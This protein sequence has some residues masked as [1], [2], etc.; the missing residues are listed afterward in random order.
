ML[1]QFFYFL[2]LLTFELLYFRVAQQLN[3]KDIPNERSSHKH[4]T[5]LG[6]GLIFVF[7]ILLFS[8]AYN[9]SYPWMLGG[10]IILAV[11]SFMDDIKPLSY[12]FRLAIQVAALLL[13]FYE[14]NLYSYPVIVVVLVI[15]LAT[16]VLNAYNF[17]DGINGL[18]GLSTLVVLGGMIYVNQFIINFVDMNFLY[19]MFMSVLIFNF[20]N[21]RKKAYCFAGDVG[22][23]TM[24]FVMVFLLAR[25]ISVSGDFTWITMLTIFGVDPLF[26]LIHRIFLRE[27]LTLPHRK[28]LFQ[29]FANELNVSHLV[30]ATVYATIQLFII[31]GLILCQ[32]YAYVFAI[33]SVVILSVVYILVKKRFYPI[34]INKEL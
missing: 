29:I 17:M 23:F 14:V 11:V 19:L 33:F 25:L 30:I 31:V 12:R 34:H 10:A 4:I 24:G 26:T 5:L 21:F 6:G 15:F 28:H 27:R 1:N 18:M 8:V 2:I 22:A 16:G 3:I 13:L 20:F 7:A 9:F 32:P